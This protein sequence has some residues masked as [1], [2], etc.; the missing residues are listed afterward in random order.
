M[1]VPEHYQV[2]LEARWTQ[3]NSISDMVECLSRLMYLYSTCEYH[4]SSN[5]SYLP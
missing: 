2:E 4:T 1:G 5:G 3:D